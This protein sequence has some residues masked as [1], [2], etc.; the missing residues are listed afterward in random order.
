M[1]VGMMANAQV[2]VAE[3]AGSFAPRY[4]TEQKTRTHGMMRRSRS[5]IW[6]FMGYFLWV[7]RW[8]VYLDKILAITVLSSLNC[9]RREASSARRRSASRARSMFL[10]SVVG[11]PEGWFSRPHR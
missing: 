8:E 1:I 4:L 3:S 2:M 7:W 11:V 6:R 9:G 10:W 5:V